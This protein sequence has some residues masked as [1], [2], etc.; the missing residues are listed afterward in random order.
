MIKARFCYTRSTEKRV[1]I[2]FVAM[3]LDVSV[4]N[5][6]AFV[7]GGHGKTMVPLTPRL[8]GCRDPYHGVDTTRPNRG[9]YRAPEM[10]GLKSC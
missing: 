7:L 6:L 9:P 1:L 5:I 10:R 8:D 4:E 2:N 3:E